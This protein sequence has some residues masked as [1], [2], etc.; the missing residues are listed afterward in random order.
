[1]GGPGSDHRPGGFATPRPPGAVL[2]PTHRKPGRPNIA[3]EVR[4]LILRLA[5]EKP[6]W[7]YRRIHGELVGLGYRVGASAVWRTYTFSV[8][9]CWG[10]YRVLGVRW[11]SFP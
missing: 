1:V 10:W 6:T 11:L 5:A 9:A 8:V 7:G 3:A 2:G 4:Q